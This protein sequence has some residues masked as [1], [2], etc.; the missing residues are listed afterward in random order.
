MVNLLSGRSS[1]RSINTQ[2]SYLS[3]LRSLTCSLH[4]SGCRLISATWLTSLWSRMC[5]SRKSTWGFHQISLVLTQTMSKVRMLLSSLLLRWDSSL[6]I[7][8]EYSTTIMLTAYSRLFI[9]TQMTQALTSDIWSFSVQWRLTTNSW[10]RI[11]LIFHICIVTMR[12]L[13]L[14][15]FWKDSSTWISSLKQIS[16]M[17]ETSEMQTMTISRTSPR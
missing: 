14:V 7:P 6:K 10:T 11:R 12:I 15:M 9:L 4:H 2:D 5:K 17:Q 3:S 1:R 13:N 16:I 8:W